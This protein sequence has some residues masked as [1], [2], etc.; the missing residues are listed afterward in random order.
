MASHQ[1][2]LQK[3]SQKIPSTLHIPAKKPINF[4]ILKKTLQTHGASVLQRYHR[5][6]SLG[7]VLCSVPPRSTWVSEHVAAH[8]A[9]R[10]SIPPALV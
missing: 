1:Y 9:V 3:K 5:R 6:G 7:M 4:A 8:L 2:V 10:G